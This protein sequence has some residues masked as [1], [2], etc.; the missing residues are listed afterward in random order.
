MESQ[1]VLKGDTMKIQTR[2]IKS[3]QS[4]VGCCGGK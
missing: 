3:N 4:T 2:N 1:S